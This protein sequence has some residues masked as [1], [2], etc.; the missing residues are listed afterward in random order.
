MMKTL[1]ELR[2]RLQTQKDYLRAHFRVTNLAIFGSYAR[3][4]QTEASDLDVLIEYEQAPTLWM[5][6]ELRSY[7]SHL[8]ELP[9]DIVT[10]PSLKATMRERILAE[11]I[12]L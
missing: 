3:G 7:L 12:P 1:L 4:E 2:D 6:A 11:A 9:V 8:L 5:L 10:Q